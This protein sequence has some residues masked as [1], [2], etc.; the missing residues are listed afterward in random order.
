MYKF[1]YLL[2][3]LAQSFHFYFFLLFFIA[4]YEIHSFYHAI[5]S[6]RMFFFSQPTNFDFFK[7][8]IFAVYIIV[9]QFGQLTSFCSCIFFPGNPVVRFLCG[10]TTEVKHEKWT[11]K[12][13]GGIYLHRR[14]LPLKL[15]WAFSIHKSQVSIF[16]KITVPLLIFMHCL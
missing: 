6:L 9:E 14:Q 7:Y 12:G 2:F 11:V 15:A 10:V 8:F 4:V 16:V 3:R 5:C 1:Q 13:S